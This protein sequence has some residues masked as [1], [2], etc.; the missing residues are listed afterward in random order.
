MR[1]ATIIGMTKKTAT[2][3]QSN[4]NHTALSVVKKAA[5]VK[6]R[7]AGKEV[8]SSS[9]KPAKSSKKKSSKR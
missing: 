2:K 3:A 1:S 6:L 4:S 7:A 9:A 5:S 8:R